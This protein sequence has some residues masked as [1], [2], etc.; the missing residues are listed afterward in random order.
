MP[1]LTELFPFMA[2]DAYIQECYVKNIL[3]MTFYI[4]TLRQSILE[5]IIDKMIK[6]DVS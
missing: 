2:R 4:P 6:L 3:H 5:L 1:M